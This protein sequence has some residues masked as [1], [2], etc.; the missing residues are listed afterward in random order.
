MKYF[1]ESYKCYP[2]VD[3]LFIGFKLRAKRIFPFND[4]QKA[5][6]FAVCQA[7]MKGSALVTDSNHN[8]ICALNT[9]ESNVFYWFSHDSGCLLIKDIRSDYQ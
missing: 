8:R 5:F 1:V 6:R 2:D 7:A 9:T 3:T 4:K